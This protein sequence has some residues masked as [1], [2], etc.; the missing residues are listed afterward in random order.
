MKKVLSGCL[1]IFLAASFAFAVLAVDVSFL[2]KLSLSELLEL[3]AEV[4][5][6]VAAS[7]GVDAARNPEERGIWEIRYYVDQF[8]DYTDE[9]YVTNTNWIFG[10]QENSVTSGIT[11][12]MQ[13]LIDE[14]D[15]AIKIYEY[16][17]TLLRNN[18]S[19]TLDEY[20]ISVK[21]AA[22]KTYQLSGAIYPNSDRIFFTEADG[23]TLLK[24]LAAGGTA[25]FV[26]TDTTFAQTKYKF[27]V[28]G[29]YLDN[30]YRQLTGK[31]IKDL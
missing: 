14:Y 1:A 3:Q 31:E 7:Q 29:A 6:R 19:N 26:V 23:K 24:I 12:K 9:G 13:F 27:E 2:D 18:F 11:M 25:K 20:Q 17:N 21:D 28:P 4:N 16:G 15:V 30:A 22:G 10:T 8:D 5:K